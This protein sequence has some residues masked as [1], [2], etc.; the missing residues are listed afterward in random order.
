[1]VDQTKTQHDNIS[2]NISRELRLH[3]LNGN[4]LAGLLLS[5]ISVFEM[6]MT[7]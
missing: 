2:I 4:I 7:S 6:N 3:F 1:M 5:V